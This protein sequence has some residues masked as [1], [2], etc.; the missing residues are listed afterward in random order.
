MGGPPLES[1]TSQYGASL[2]GSASAGIV[3][4]AAVEGAASGVGE[5][6]SGYVVLQPVRCGSWPHECTA[7]APAGVGPALAAVLSGVRAE[8]GKSFARASMSGGGPPVGTVDVLAAPAPAASSALLCGS[9]RASTGTAASAVTVAPVG[10][11]LLFLFSDAASEAPAAPATLGMSATGSVRAVVG[12]SG[13]GGA[14]GAS[15]R[16]GKACGV[17]VDAGDG[18]VSGSFRS[19]I[20]RTFVAQLLSICSASVGASAVRG[21]RTVVAESSVAGVPGGTAVA[22]AAFGDGAPVGALREVGGVD[23]AAGAVSADASG[24]GVLGTVV[25]SSPSGA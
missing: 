4:V 7:R 17:G 19:S 14:S 12:T 16:G 1:G 21:E 22:G 5:A 6:A 11:L 15:G 10:G 24:S 2:E 25:H 3:G 18:S 20:S 8:R 23:G 9:D 13:D